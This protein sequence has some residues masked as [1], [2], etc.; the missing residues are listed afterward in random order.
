MATTEI[1]R[2]RTRYL[3]I[4]LMSSEISSISE[5]IYYKQNI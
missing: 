2:P 1:T 4:F 5:Y 3:I